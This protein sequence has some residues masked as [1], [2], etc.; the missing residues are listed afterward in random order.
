MNREEWLISATA[1]LSEL[2]K[3]QGQ[4]VP[5]TRVSV[6]F[7]PSGG[8][9][10]KVIGVCVAG[11][12]AEDSRAQ[13][14]IHPTLED[15]RRVL[16]VLLHELIHAVLPDAGHGALFKQLAESVGLTGKMTATVASDGLN[17]V[18]SEIVGR[19]GEY[20]HASLTLSGRKQTTRLIKCECDDCGYIA[21]VSGKWL[22]ELG[23][24][25]CPCNNESMRVR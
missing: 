19:I 18:L 8:R 17:A 13:I 2:I 23:A 12:C 4:S 20:P 11:S 14:F 5:E 16:D 15:S 7:P 24:P 10:G 21:R 1:E 3:G 25:I 9:S 22:D 6:G